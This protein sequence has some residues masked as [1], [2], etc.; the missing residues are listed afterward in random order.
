VSS[1]IILTAARRL[2]A[3][4]EVRGLFNETGQML[5]EKL[6]PDDADRVAQAARTAAGNELS[7]VFDEAR[8]EMDKALNAR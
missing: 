6:S 7:R 2:E 1:E 8:A 3:V 4:R 5:V